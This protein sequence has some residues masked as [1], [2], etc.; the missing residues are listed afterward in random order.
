MMGI[1]EKLLQ[2]KQSNEE[3]I[4]YLRE[5][6]QVLILRIIYNKG[7]FGNLS[8]VGGTALRFLYDLKRF[9]EDLDFSLIE[10]KNY[11]FNKLSGDLYR[12]LENYGFKLDINKKDSKIVQT[13]DLKFKN[14]LHELNLSPIKSHKILIRLEID[15][16]P[17]K[18][19]T[20]QVTLINKTYIFTVTHFDLSSLYALKLHACFYRKYTK[21]RD[22][23]DLIWYLSKKSEPNY[24]LLNNAIK[25]TE[26]S[27]VKINKNN[28]KDFLCTKIEKIDFKKVKRDVERFL[29]DKNEL[30]LFDKNLI[31]NT[32]KSSYL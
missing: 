20:T 2:S 5:F 21:G 24:L 23:Y 26:K 6:L 27:V 30:R 18:G 11:I 8:F 4:N 13:I 14:I 29:E 1:L 16:N 22:F 9:S 19:W 12:E 28:F 32:I 3:K 31:L 17:P 7:Y 25:Q 10:K 15:T